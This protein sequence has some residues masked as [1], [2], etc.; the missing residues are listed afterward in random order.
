MFDTPHKLKETR[1]ACPFY[2]YPVGTGQTGHKEQQ[3]LPLLV[4]GFVIQGHCQ[5]ADRVREA[6]WHI[7]NGTDWPVWEAGRDTAASFMQV[8]PS[9]PGNTCEPCFNFQFR[10]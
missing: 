7:I 6:T 8:P 10:M 9:F 4:A 1:L 2:F 3:Q 5:A